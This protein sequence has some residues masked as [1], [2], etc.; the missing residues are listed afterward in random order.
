MVV[1]HVCRPRYN[2]V[3]AANHAGRRRRRRGGR[4]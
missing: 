4:R 3:G 1:A 2:D